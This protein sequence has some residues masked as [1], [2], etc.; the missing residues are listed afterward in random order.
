MFIQ[1]ISGTVKDVD[2]ME[3]EAERWQQELRP[4]AAGY[5][6]MTSGVTDDNR[7]VTVVRFESAE[8]AK[9]NSERPEQGAWWA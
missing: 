3:R 2:A 8:A 4:G 7:Y 9:A 1:A 6:G 5:L